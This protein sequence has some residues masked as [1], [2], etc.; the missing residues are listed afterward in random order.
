MV[1][2]KIDFMADTVAL[3]RTLFVVTLFFS[4]L[5]SAVAVASTGVEPE[6]HGKTVVAFIIFILYWGVFPVAPMDVYFQYWVV[7]S[8]IGCWS[9]YGVAN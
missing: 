9:L 6:S 5:P 8:I 2:F 7:F 1:A 3:V 4:Q